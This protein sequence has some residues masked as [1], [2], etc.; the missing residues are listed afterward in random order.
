[1]MFINPQSI[2]CGTLL[3]QVPIK[4]YPWSMRLNGLNQIP[5]Y[6]CAMSSNY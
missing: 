1:M 4:I 6:P 5:V 2:L 3:A